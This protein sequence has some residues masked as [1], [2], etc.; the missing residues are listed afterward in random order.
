MLCSASSS[1]PCSAWRS[2]WAVPLSRFVSFTEDFSTNPFTAWSFGIGS[3]DPSTNRFVWNSSAA[4]AY[5][6]DPVG[7]L[8]V[9]LDSSLPTVRFQRPLGVTVTDTDDFLLKA[10][11]SFTVTSAPTNQSMQIAFGLVNSSLTGGN[12][13]G[14]DGV[15]I[16]DDTFHTVEFNYFPQIS[17]FSSPPTGPTLSPAVFGAHK[18]GNDAF[19]NFA[20]YFL[21]EADLH[22][23]TNGIHELPQNVTLEA[24]LAYRS[25]TKT[26]TLTM[27]QVNGDNSTTLLETEV[28]P[29]S[30]INLPPFGTYDTN[31]P[32]QVDTL[33]IMAYRDGFTATNDPSLVA[34]VT[35]QRLSFYAPPPEPPCVAI[36]IVSANVF[37]TFPTASNFLYDVQS[38]SDLASG[39]WSTVASNIAGTGGIVTNIDVGAA[40]AS[41]RFYR[42]GVTVP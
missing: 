41:R 9:H 38:R 8:D 18:P 11:F 24:V 33:A 17:T 26:I 14:S 40:T 13:T 29:M 39:S 3:G 34:D 30:L 1:P 27:N 21:S 36:N 16:D 10:R 15:F 31:F 2:R 5:T 4:S 22:D 35:F 42:V 37:L 28:P 7:A 20:A 12:R 6:G 19:G 23:N 25:A 32:F